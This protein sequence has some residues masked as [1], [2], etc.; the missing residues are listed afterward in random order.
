MDDDPS[1]R[2]QRFGAC[3]VGLG[4]ESHAQESTPSLRWRENVECS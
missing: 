1:R 3:N 4:L 2:H